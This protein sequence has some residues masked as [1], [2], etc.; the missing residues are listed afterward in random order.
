M[1]SLQV[2]LVT[3]AQQCYTDRLD[4]VDTVLAN[5]AAIFDNLNITKCGGKGGSVGIAS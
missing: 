2:A 4:L 1:V 5:T 3:L